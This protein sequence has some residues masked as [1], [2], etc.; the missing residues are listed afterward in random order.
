MYPIDRILIAFSCQVG[1]RCGE[2]TWFRSYWQLLHLLDLKS[3]LL[4]DEP[5]NIP[6]F[7]MRGTPRACAVEWNAL[8]AMGIRTSIFEES[9]SARL[10][11]GNLPFDVTEDDLKELFAPVGQLSNI[12]LPV[13]RETGKKRGFA[14]VEF[15]ESAQAAEALRRFSNQEFKGRPLAVSEARARESHPAPAQPS[16]SRVPRITDTFDSGSSMDAGGGR[17]E[18]RGR[19]QARRHSK[20]GGFG[21]RFDESARKGPRRERAGGRVFGLDYDDL[22]EEE[23]LTGDEVEE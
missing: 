14:F 16:R 1:A 4:H 13:D 5:R 2:D 6:A 8:R 17:R 12:F 15:A 22:G 3:S 9:M 21:G 19:G 20:S 11:V 10:F 7:G 23:D 18:R